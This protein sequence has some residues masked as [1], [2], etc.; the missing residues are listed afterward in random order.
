MK[1][2]KIICSIITVI[3]ILL[4]VALILVSLKGNM[5]VKNSIKTYYKAIYVALFVMCV[6]GYVGIKNKL[7]DKLSNKAIS[8]TISNIY[9]YF[10]LA[11][12]VFVSRGV[13]AYLLV[14]KEVVDVIPSINM[15]L[16]SYINYGLGHVFN[17]Q[18]YANCMINGVIAFVSCIIIK[19]IML[20]I[21]QNDTISTATS[22][23]FLFIPSAL[24]SVTQYVRY[25]YNVMLLLVGIL[26]YI[27]IIDE[28]K[29]FKKNSNK[30]IIYSVRLGVI[31]A[32][33]IMF[34]GSY[35]MW[36]SMLLVVT[37][38]AMYIDTIHLHI[39]FK[40]N[41]QYKLKRVVEKIEKIHISKLVCVLLISLAISGITTLVYGL[42]LNTNNYQAF[43]VEN[44][45]NVLIHSKNYYL[46]FLIFTLVFEIV[47][48][49]LKRKLDIKMFMI[50]VVY[51]T[52]GIITFFMVDGI[53]ASYVFDT[54]LVL[55]VIIN[56]CN[57]CYNREERI[58]LLKEK[59]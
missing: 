48:L 44:S 6:F 19:K 8:F 22:I 7:K 33:D 21:T 49:I 36:V 11:T 55:T 56:V 28:V 52:T 1:R 30:Y 14:N 58:K 59:N 47:G 29:K 40:E 37:L 5:L 42:F 24:S 43:S 31:Q 53:H 18:I 15:G 10:Y 3:Y 25:G 32:L 50:K 57:I 45:I 34:G 26:L 51:I 23:M 27:N 12:I 54:L 4:S 13:M 17:S 9:C 35:F 2:S 46:V 41:L 38:A 20:N 39:W 16:G